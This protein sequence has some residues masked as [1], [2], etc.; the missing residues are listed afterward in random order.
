[1]PLAVTIQAEPFTEHSKANTP[2]LA[3][4]NEYR[5]LYRDLERYTSGQILGRS[6]LIAGH[7]GSGKSM[8]VHKAIEDLL[9]NS[10]EKPQRP[11]FVRLHGPDLLPPIDNGESSAKHELSATP[12]ANQIAI[13]FSG[14]SPASVNTTAQAADNNKA[15]N[16]M[17]N[18]LTE[19]MKSLFRDVTNEFRKSFREAVLRTEP[20]IHRQEMLELAAQFDL[21]IV[22][23]LNASQ[24]R[25][26][27]DRIGAL[28]SGVL[29][30]T[31]RSKY[32]VFSKSDSR[33]TELFASDLGMQEILVLTFLSQAF[34]VISG[35]IEERQRQANAAKAEISS[36]LNT[37]YALKDLLAPIAGL[38]AGIG[39][40][41][42]IGTTNGVIGVLLGL[43][44]GSVVSV[45][46]SY[47]SS[48][49]RNREVSSESVFIR[50]RSVATLSSVLP[51][52]VMRL[53]QI[54]LA[55]VF[56]VDELDKVDDIEG[57]MKK[58]VQHLKYMVTENSFSCFLTDRRYHAYLE[59][60]ANQT[61]YAPEYTYFSDRLL[62]LYAPGELRQF[63][64]DVLQTVEPDPKDE[65]EAAQAGILREKDD[66]D[67]EKIAYV[68][69]HRARM[70]PIDLRREIDRL[71]T[72]KSFSMADFFPAPRYRFEIFIQLAIEWSLQGEDVQT[73]IDGDPDSRQM[74][75]DA[76]YYVSRLWE[77]ASTTES[78]QVPG[79]KDFGEPGDEKPG[80]ILDRK[81]FSEYIASRYAPDVKPGG[82][83]TKKTSPDPPNPHDPPHQDQVRKGAGTDFEFLFL[84]ARELLNWLTNPDGFYE[85][86]ANSPRPNKPPRFILDEIPTTLPLIRSLKGSNYQW[87]YDASGRILETRDVNS[88]VG[89]V[90]QPIGYIRRTESYIRSMATLQVFSDLNVMPRTPEWQDVEPMMGRLQ[91]LLSDKQKQPYDRMSMDRDSVIEFAETLR[92][93]EPNLKAAVMC[94]SM[95]VPYIGSPSDSA[96][97]SEESQRGQFATALANVHRLLKLSASESDLVNMNSV[98]KAESSLPAV[99]SQMEWKD[100]ADSSG[101]LRKKPSPAADKL[102]EVAKLSWDTFKNRFNQHF[103]NGSAKFEPLLEDLVTSLKNI[104][105]GRY[106]SFDLSTIPAANWSELLMR[107]LADSS[108]VP[109][110]MGVAAALE[111]GFSELAGKLSM[112][113]AV[114]SVARKWI[115]D[116]KLRTG[117][118]PSNR[119]SVLLLMAE[120]DSLASQWLPSL[121][122]AALV[123]T[124]QN[125]NSL[126]ASLRTYEIVKPA[127]FPIDSFCLELKGTRETI[128][129]QVVQ[130]PEALLT[131][132]PPGIKA[133]IEPFL[134]L[135]ARCYLVPETPAELSSGKPSPPDMPLAIAPR[136][137]DQMILA[138]WG[139]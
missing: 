85:E 112:R 35:R 99:P 15:D 42:G 135:R 133:E 3:R 58:L 39:V 116:W 7:R 62:V 4:S 110:W 106:L 134:N 127:D 31:D 105:A 59:R 38:I 136:S 61:A 66:Q 17:I 45:A 13:A 56:V 46:F 79:Y 36:S 69:L 44:T 109:P 114:D 6:Y 138:A 2:V 8:L 34:R 11:L 65:K 107:S 33:E 10:L 70:H 91:R 24:L 93:F 47:G 37:A 52:L 129:Q 122:H 94:A 5:R 41:V 84:K 23:G 20:G 104:G 128:A 12:P 117:T 72:R 81:T 130:K 96:P 124:L 50:D 82:D 121:R 9:R 90:R 76:L 22:E 126:R 18:V 68:L 83:G 16:E 77:D 103:R 67:R 64:K 120:R 28:A 30:V 14:D 97:S 63:V 139:S 86:L 101:S 73:Q 132:I 119:R 137:L 111:L 29:F 19:M 98:L 89:D 48:R 25:F 123:C 125:F 118:K 108:H 43:L 115:D 54:G 27:W 80:F 57:R 21:E 71:A 40:G 75:Y 53:K 131:S 26:Y 92:Q 55:P 95:L 100:V 49:S 60:Q 1:M 87:L 78:A 51:L 113:P 88:I 102:D 74:L 32:R